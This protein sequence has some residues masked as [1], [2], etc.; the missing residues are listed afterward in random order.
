VIRG[1]EAA[2]KGTPFPQAEC[3]R[4][5]IGAADGGGTPRPTYGGA[6]QLKAAAWNLPGRS[7]GA[8]RLRDD[9]RSGGVKSW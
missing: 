2:E 3:S 1:T 4:L 9:A 7:G 6:E 5:T 8:E